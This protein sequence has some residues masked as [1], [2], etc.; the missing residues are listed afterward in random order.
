MRAT[1]WHPILS[2]AVAL[3]PVAVAQYD[4]AS[5]KSDREQAIDWV[6]A[7]NAFGPTHDLVKDG[8]AHLDGLTAERPDFLFELGANLTKSGKETWLLGWRNRFWVFELSAAQSAGHDKD[9][10]RKYA[11][12]RTFDN[13]VRRDFEIRPPAFPGPLPADR[14]IVGK[15]PFKNLG[16][17]STGYTTVRLAYW[18]GKDRY[19]SYSHRPSRFV[20]KEE[21]EWAFKFAPPEVEPGPTLFVFEVIEYADADRT[22][23]PVVVSNPAVV[24]VDVGPAAGAAAVPKAG[25][26]GEPGR[27][28]PEKIE[29]RPATTKGVDFVRV[30][31]GTD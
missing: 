2:L 20:G 1:W 19:V 8:K 26:K 27:A 23:K 25:A 13:F 9:R 3:V 6:K 28:T 4:P 7:K 15:L 29:P 31:R 30:A 11:L 10:M 24:L 16:R 14:D 17:V 21:N 18:R 5:K 12:D 22:S